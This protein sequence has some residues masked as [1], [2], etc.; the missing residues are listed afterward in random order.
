MSD[1]FINRYVYLIIGIGVIATLVFLAF[2]VALTGREE[3]LR[4]QALPTVQQDITPVMGDEELYADV[5]PLPIDENSGF[6]VEELPDDT[7]GDVLYE[8]DIPY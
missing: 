4:A 7:F 1:S 2:V 3:I 5:P 6:V 8:P